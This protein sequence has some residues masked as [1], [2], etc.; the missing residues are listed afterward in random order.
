MANTH[1]LD[2]ESS[3]SQYAY[4][5]DANQ[6]GLDLTTD[7]TIEFWANFET[8]AGS[9]IINKYENG[10]G[11]YL[12][13]LSGSN[14]LKVLYSADGTNKS[15]SYTTSAISG[16]GWH[17]YA[18]VVDISNPADTKI[19]IDCVSQSVTDNSTN[20]TSLIGTSV[21]FHI[22]ANQSP[23]EYFDG[24]IDEVRIWNDIRTQQEIQDN[25]QKELVGNETNLVGY[26]KFNND[27]TDETSN[28]NDLTA[29]GSPVFST[30]VPFTG[31]TEVVV[32]AIENTFTLEEPILHYGVNIIVDAIENTFTL[33]EP[34]IELPININVDTIENTFTLEN[35]KVIAWSKRTK[36]NTTWNKRTKPTTNWTKQ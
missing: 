27:Y 8:I 9:T 2:L 4:I 3:S 17:H 5:T 19:Y 36:P 33:E 10:V 20:A 23:A 24:L 13:E 18:I 12:V 25:Y 35:V 1:S 30:D 15:E 22:G 31:S 29:S 34:N 21:P 16:T 14:N 7:F 28:G 26:W 11:G 6:T 32:D